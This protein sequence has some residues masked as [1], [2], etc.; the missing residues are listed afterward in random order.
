VPAE[1]V[2]ASDTVRAD[3]AFNLNGTDGLSATYAYPASITV[4]GG[5]ITA[6]TAGSAANITLREGAAVD[7]TEA[8][9]TQDG[10]WHDLDLSAVLPAGTK[11]FWARVVVNADA[12]G[13]V[14]YL[15]K[16]GNTGSS[17]VH[18]I[19][20]QVAGLTNQAD[21]GPVGV[22]SSRV[23]EYMAT[24]QSGFTWLDMQLM[25]QSYA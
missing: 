10:A 6:A 19:P 12:A 17:D 13:K 15:R 11:M 4:S 18:A 25:I 22:D 1:N 7:Y 23:V 24:N 14:F 20:T 9:F 3:T 2:H 16:N 8:S 5:I 21:V